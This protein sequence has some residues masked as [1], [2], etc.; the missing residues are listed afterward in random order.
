MN[1]EKIFE[2]A[3]KKWGEKNQLIVACEEL[4]E[5]IQSITKYLRQKDK[6]TVPYNLAEETADVL[7]MIEQMIIMLDIKVPVEDIYKL[8]IKRL[9]K[10]LCQ[11]T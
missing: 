6:T 9:E 2:Q 7:I 8:K 10:L 4:A 11:S 3:L 1:D 5:L